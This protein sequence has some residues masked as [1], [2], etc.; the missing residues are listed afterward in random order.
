M[1]SR[2]RAGRRAGLTLATLAALALVSCA[3]VREPVAMTAETGPDDSLHLAVHDPSIAKRIALGNVFTDME[4]GLL[5]AR[6][7]LANKGKRDL[8]VE[9]QFQWIDAAGDEIPNAEE[10]WQP[11][12]LRGYESAVVSATATDPAA[13]TFRINLTT[14]K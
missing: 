9:Y 1:D 5:R 2:T 12:L 4:S 14:R 3:T 8:P 13:A 6:V 7:T 11:L 10:P